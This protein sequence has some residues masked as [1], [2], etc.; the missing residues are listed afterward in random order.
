MDEQGVEVIPVRASN[1]YKPNSSV[2][3]QRSKKWVDVKMKPGNIFGNAEDDFV[4]IGDGHESRTS[5]LP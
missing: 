3:G 2:S 4:V 1:S 5:K